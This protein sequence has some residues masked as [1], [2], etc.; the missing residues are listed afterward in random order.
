MIKG[1]PSRRNPFLRLMFDESLYYLAF[2]FYFVICALEHTTFTEILFIPVDILQSVLQAATLMLLLLKFVMQ[3]ASFKGWA[4]AAALVLIGFLS[5]R[6]SGEGWLFWVSLFVVCA[7][8]VRL[9]PLAR[10]SFSLSLATVVTAMAFAGA[11]IIE[12]VVATRAGVTRYAMGF[13]HANSL[14]LYLLIICMSFSVLRFGKNPLPDL[15]L[16]GVADAINLAT[17][18]SRT[19]VL[20]SVFQAALLV[21]FYVLRSETARRRARF[22]FGVAVFLVIA[23]SVY[24]MVSYDAFSAW[25]AALNNLLSGRLNLAHR[26]FLMQPLTLLGSDFSGYAPIYWENGKTYAFVVDNAWCHLI[27]RFGV[28]PAFAFIVGYGLLLL[29]ML[30]GKRWD[31]LLFGIVLMAVYG[32]SETLGVRFECNYF[33]FALGAELLYVSPAAKELFKSSDRRDTARKKGGI[34]PRA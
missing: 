14:G 34:V 30:R 31:A 12:N 32:F 18:D 6:R 28:L 19:T 23:L 3:R 33:L 29:R 25:Q 2:S 11:G 13:S 4:I 26:Y 5:W 9:R 17:A 21:S 10:L 8:G 20:L 1:K 27:L 15:A 24:F 16:I 22:C 7:H